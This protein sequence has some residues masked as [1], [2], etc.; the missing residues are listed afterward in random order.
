MAMTDKEVVD[1]ADRMARVLL[2]AWGYEFSGECVRH[3]GNPRAVAA[4]SAV[5]R[6]L[7]EYNGTDLPSAV[8]SVDEDEPL[9]DAMPSRHVSLI[10]YLQ[11]GACNC[12]MKEKEDFQAHQAGCNFRLLSEIEQMLESRHA[13]A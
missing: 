4:W 8:D 6:M 11:R 2:Q 13:E 1:G 12:P 7:E 5:S 10:Q 3:S 9:V